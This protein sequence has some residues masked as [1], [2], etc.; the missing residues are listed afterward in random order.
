MKGHLYITNRYIAS[1]TYGY[2]VYDLRDTAITTSGPPADPPIREGLYL[3]SLV[4]FDKPSLPT[5]AKL[6]RAKYQGVRCRPVDGHGADDGALLS[7][8]SCSFIDFSEQ[9]LALYETGQK[10]GDH[11]LALKE[12]A[13]PLRIK[14]AQRGVPLSLMLT[15]SVCPEPTVSWTRPVKWL[16]P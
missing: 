7:V 12:P 15:L 2:K 1:A 14:S 5:L 8:S 9:A 4:A 11:R 3:A 13:A 6:A 10:V 16:L